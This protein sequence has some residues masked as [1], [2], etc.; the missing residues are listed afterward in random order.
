[1]SEKGV[2]IEIQESGEDDFGVGVKLGTEN[3]EDYS[4]ENAG[5]NNRVKNTSIDRLSAL[6]DC[7]LIHILSFLGVKK[8][9]VTS[10]LGKEWKSLWAELPVLEFRFDY[11]GKHEEIKNMADLVAWVDKKML[12]LVAWVNKTLAIRNGTYLEKLKVGF[13]YKKC[14]AQDVD[15]WLEFAL[16][17]KAK[18]VSLA[19]N[20]NGFFR[21]LDIYTLPEMMYSNSFLT[22]L[23]L[24]GC[25]LDPE[26]TI[27]WPSLTS[28]KISRVYLPQPVLEM[29][30]SGCPVL[31]SMDLSGCC[32]FTCLEINSKSLYNLRVQ[33]FEGEEEESDPFLQ[34]S[35]PY[36]KSLSISLY[37]EER[38]LKL[39]NL[40][41]LDSAEFDF[42]EHIWSFPAEVLS[43][44]KEYFENIHHAKDLVL[45]SAPVKALARLVMNGWQLPK[46]RLR[47]LT[48]KISLYAVKIIPGI[49]CLLESSPDLETLIIDSI[50]SDEW[51]KNRLRPA[52]GD[53]DSDLLHLKTV[54]LSNLANPRIGGEP[55]LTLARILLK[56]ATILEEMVIKADNITTSDSD[57]L[58]QTLLTYPIS[59]PNAVILLS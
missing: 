4:K 8:A 25:R 9:G 12:D 46:S 41:S 15:N 1:M 39:T 18:E 49:L 55:M 57:K 19:L 50:D 26:I 36:L 54:K 30:L 20:E 24:D 43:N 53:L 38:K 59:S 42:S 27:K 5:A 44:A 51:D 31:N 56:R 16:K 37:P 47:C 2:A 13:L 58:R 48:I 45:G 22:S 7:L 14:F 40:S 3:V 52:K 35:A 34:I 28:L 32:G 17:N 21:T 11:S 6:P 29:I 10:L 23:S 33:N